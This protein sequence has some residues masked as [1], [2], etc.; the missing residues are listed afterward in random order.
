MPANDLADELASQ[1][2]T[3]KGPAHR[4]LVPTC[5]GHVTPWS[6]HHAQGKRIHRICQPC[7]LEPEMRSDNTEGRSL[8]LVFA[9]AKHG[10]SIHLTDVHRPLKQESNKGSI[11]YHK[12]RKDTFQDHRNMV[13]GTEYVPCLATTPLISW[14]REAI[15]QTLSSCKHLAQS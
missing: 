7:M 4:S 8:L 15:V 6:F 12:I 9:C 13:S 3:R 2:S 11:P 5:C 1:R 14:S 10:L